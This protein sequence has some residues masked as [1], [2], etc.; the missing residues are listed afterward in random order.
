VRA[1]QVVRLDGP[2][3]VEVRDVPEPRPR[4]DDVLIDVRAAGVNF[5]DVLQ[6]RGLY[7]YRPE[8]PFTLG[9]EVAGVVREAPAR[10]A[11]QPGDRVVAF[12]GTGAFADAVAVNADHVLPLPAEVPFPAGACLPM[13]YLTAHFALLVRGGLR[14]GQ[15]VLVHGAAGGVGTASV[16]L[17]AALGARVIAVVSSTAKH[18][19]ALAAGAHATVGVRGFR[20]AVK[21]LTAGG[22]VDLVVDPVGGDR[23]TDSLRCLAPQ[24]K[25]LVIGFTAGEIPTVK[26]NRLLLNNIDVVGV[27]WGGYALGRTGYLAGQWAELEPHLRSGLLNPL[28]SATI[29][30][31]LAADA[32]ARID[33]RRVTGKV[34]LQT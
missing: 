31:E 26:V 11:V 34:V 8:L 27:G 20:E 14:A 16:Q 23:F 22:G 6:T 32:L 2:S 19:V 28:I 4:G 21:E 10:A 18:E 30:L 3:A 25:L 24:G 1:V 29:S 7:Q 9:S 5:P 12:T 13:N 15:S 17:A 33:E